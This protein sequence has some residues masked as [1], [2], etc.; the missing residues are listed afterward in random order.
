MSKYLS[1]GNSKVTKI[2]VD[3][4]KII[5]VWKHNLNEEMENI[6][7]IVEKYNYISMV[8]PK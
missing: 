5:D 3:K 6:M 4:F 1:H 7:K 2:D 8:S